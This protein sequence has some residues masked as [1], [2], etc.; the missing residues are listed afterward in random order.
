M[1]EHH[2]KIPFVMRNDPSPG[3]GVT[4]IQ[5]TSR[6]DPEKVDEVASVKAEQ[7]ELSMMVGVEACPQT[8]PSGMYITLA[9]RVGHVAIHQ[10]MTPALARS[11]AA[12]LNQAADV[13]D[14]G[15]HG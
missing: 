1:L 14:G 13:I 5:F 3:P 4:K 12:L 2:P 11:Y 7:S 15:H 8:A 6:I 10:N 9:L